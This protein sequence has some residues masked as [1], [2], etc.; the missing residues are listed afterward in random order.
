MYSE[1]Q[2]RATMKYRKNNYATITLDVKKD[3]KPLYV[4]LAESKGYTLTAYVKY[5]LDRE[6]LL[7][8]EKT[9]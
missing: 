2:K 6:L 8:D 4:A 3:R 5:L 9:R 1:A 7:S